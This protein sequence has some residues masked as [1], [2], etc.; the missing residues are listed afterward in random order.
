MLP[1]SYLFLGSIFYDYLRAL[2][3]LEFAPGRWYIRT[4]TEK[5]HGDQ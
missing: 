5:I 1:C 2:L 3:N 4:V